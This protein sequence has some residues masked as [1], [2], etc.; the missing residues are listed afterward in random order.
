MKA[1]FYNY[2]GL[3]NQENREN[4]L[5]KTIK[6]I[7]KEETILDAGA[8]EL[9]YKKY[10]KGLKYT[11]QDFGLYD[12]EGNEDA[13]QTGEW[14]NSK[15][16]IV[17]DIIDIPVKE[18]SFDNIMCIE[19]FEHLPE[20]KLAIKE[21]ARILKPKGKLIITAPFCSLTHFAPYHFGTG[22][23]KY[24]YEK[25]LEEYGFSV[26]EISHNGNYFEY[27]AQEL[28]RIESMGKKYSKMNFLK[29]IMLKILIFPLLI[30]LNNL[31][32]YDKKS[33]ELLCFG[34][35]ILAEKR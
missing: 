29:K 14:D 25:F 18:K 13:L 16:D 26:L 3:K 17:S 19:V 1:K 23:S 28:H 8:G 9:Q 24:F 22:Y 7:P 34:L 5:Q 2:C 15:L 10:C 6:K 12:G 31:S 21:F 30:F 4:W 11:S 32:K 27:I 20:P 35:H 33:N